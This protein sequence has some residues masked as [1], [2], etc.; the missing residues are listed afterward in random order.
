MPKIADIEPTPNPNAVKFILREPL[1]WGIAHSYENAEQAQ[2]DP[3]ASALFAIP[4]VTNVFYVDRWITITQDGEALWED[5]ARELAVPL[6][7]APAAA[8][9]A[10]AGFGSHRACHLDPGAIPG[11]RGDTRLCRRQGRADQLQ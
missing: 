10:R 8:G 2:A 6:R 4:H 1:S 7:A 9:D 3:L 5:L 11:V